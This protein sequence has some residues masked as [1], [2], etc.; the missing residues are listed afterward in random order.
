MFTKNGWPL[1]VSEVLKPYWNR[2]L[3]LSLEDDCIMWGNRVVVPKKCQKRVLE[4]LHEVHFG[5]TGPLSYLVQVAGG[6]MWKCYIDQIRQIDDSPQQEQPTNKETMI[7]FP[8]ANDNEPV[9]DEPPP[10][11]ADSTPPAYR[12]PRRVH[13]PPDRLTYN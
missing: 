13:V 10:A 11:I 5:R 9:N 3:E 6:Q 4:E 8:Q 2:R 1:Q 7:R 12:Y